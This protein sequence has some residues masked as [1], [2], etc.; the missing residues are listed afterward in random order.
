MAYLVDDDGNY[1]RTCYCSW[2]YSKGHNSRACPDRYPNGTPAQRRKAA[3]EAEKAERKRLGVKAARRCTY[4]GETGHIRRKCKVLGE[5]KLR[6][7][8]AIYEYRWATAEYVKE[9]GL[10]R[11]ALLS[12][13]TDRWNYKTSSYRNIT[14]Y[15]MILDLDYA[16]LDPHQNWKISKRTNDSSTQQTPMR[17]MYVKS[18][19]G[20]DVGEV[21]RY[22]MMTHDEQGGPTKLT[23]LLCKNYCQGSSQAKIEVV[24]RGEV[25]V[26]EYY[27]NHSVIRSLVDDYFRGTK[28]KAHYQFL[29]RLDFL[30]ECEKSD[31]N[32][33]G[34]VE[35]AAQEA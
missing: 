33:Q 13:T 30:A 23:T 3:R 17:V 19:G 12:F 20:P 6:T 26:P 1:K 31:A 8:A 11:G 34:R 28:T 7:A 21:R 18:E 9:R 29:T 24:S 27:T 14:D 5:D 16:L 22:Q 35:Q 15:F 10:G 25:D 4:C 32:H 2:C